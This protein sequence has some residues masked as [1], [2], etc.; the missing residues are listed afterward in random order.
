LDRLLSTGEDRSAALLAVALWR[1]GVPARSLRG[2]EAGIRAEGPF[3]QGRIVRVEPAAV[4]SFLDEGVVPVV[5]GFQG[6]R[7]DGETITLGRGG[8]DA[9]AVALA[10]ALGAECHIVTDVH[11]I[12]D[13]DPRVTPRARPYTVLGHDDLLRLAENGAEVVQAAAARLAAAQGVTLR[14]YHFGA[15]LDGAGTLVTA[16]A[17]EPRTGKGGVS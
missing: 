14:V 17:T 12:C 15:P 2:G 4:Q 10:A 6:Q 8:S 3:G 7:G 16:R 11:A 13:T 5:S 9:S 1:E